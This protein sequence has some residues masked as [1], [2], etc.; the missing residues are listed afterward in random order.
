MYVI[1]LSPRTFMLA[2]FRLLSILRLLD[3][4]ASLLTGISC[5]WSRCSVKRR[6]LALVVLLS[7]V[8]K[9]LLHCN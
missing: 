5:F 9:H 6:L 3:L 2:A 7:V 8:L 4:A 1:W